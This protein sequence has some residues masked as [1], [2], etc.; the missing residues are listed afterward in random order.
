MRIA[1]RVGIVVQSTRMYRRRV[2]SIHVQDDL[3]MRI[4]FARYPFH[5]VPSMSGS[6]RSG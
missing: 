3:Q 1:K 5:D 2:V 6:R 4:S